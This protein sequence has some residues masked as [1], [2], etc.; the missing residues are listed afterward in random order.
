MRKPTH[1]PALAAVLVALGLAAVPPAAWASEADLSTS[2]P[3][4]DPAPAT[5]GDL[6]FVDVNVIPMD[7]E[8]V[9]SG[10]TVIVRDGRIAAIGPAA[11]VEVPAGATIVNGQGRYLVPGIA[12]M[13]AHIPPP[14]RDPTDTERTLFLY[15]ANGVTTIR[16]MLGHPGHLV[17]RERAALGEIVSPR[18][19]TSGPSFN[20]NSAPD[21]ETARRMVA[22]QLE[23]GYDLLKV[24]PGLTRAVYDAMVE[25]ANEAGLTF[26]G[27]VPADVGL[28]RALEAGQASVDHLDAY[29][30][31]LAGRGGGFN[32]REAGFFGYGLVDE[33][34]RARIRELAR[35]TAEA[36]VWNAPTLTLIE[37][38][39]DANDPEEMARRPE[40]RY[41]P[42]ATVRNWVRQK[43]AVQ[44]QRIY[45]RERADRYIELRREIL[46][47]LQASGAG[48]ILASDAPQ[49]WNVPGF[50]LHHE[51][52]MM[53][54]A[55]LTPYQILEAGT[56]NPARYFGTD[57]W[58]TLREGAIADMILL[59]ANPLDDIANMQRVE[60]VIL[61][62]RWLPADEIQ[63]GL[64]E[65]AKGVRGG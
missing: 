20:G 17:L 24:H 31:A 34:D 39:F 23:M 30:E 3:T 42:E 58:G 52:R 12:E 19:V 61:Q 18:I 56:R 60:G 14:D 36:G 35:T 10:Q 26:A 33:V 41:M 46:R 5:R 54:E 28:D 1:F 45:T 4:S 53:A 9:L 38:L 47:E 37:H 29:V 2:A 65:I 13:H 21:P 62:G 11:E 50:S 44:G 63:R 7:R 22:E 64:D 25:A 15:A 51:M 57:E 55:G 16:G 48:I 8:R 43:K 27:H 49:W 59:G 6:A 40:M 32:P